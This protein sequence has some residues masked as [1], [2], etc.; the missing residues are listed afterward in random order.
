MANRTRKLQRMIRLY[1][2]ETGELEVDLRKVAL[3]AKDKG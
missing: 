1:K 3:F 2:D